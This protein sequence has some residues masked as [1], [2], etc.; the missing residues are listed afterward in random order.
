MKNGRKPRRR[1]VS[2][3]GTVKMR[4]FMKPPGAQ[5]PTCAAGFPAT[6][7]LHRVS[8]VLR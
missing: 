4:F 7:P 8:K 5:P 1:N 3:F 2:W 6:T